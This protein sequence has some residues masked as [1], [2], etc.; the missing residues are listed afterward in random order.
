[1]FWAGIMYGRRA[2]LIAIEGTLTSVQYRDRILQPIVIPYRQE[3]GDNF[4]FQDDNARAHRSRLVNTFIHQAQIN[5]MKWPAVSPDMNPIEQV[6][7]Q[8]KRAVQQRRNPPQTL[9]DLR[10]AA[11]EEWDRLDQEC[12]NHLV[13]GV[14]RRVR[15]CCNARGGV[16]GY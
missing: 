12:L 5:R 15:A 3:F 11:I 4:V 7:D 1:M 2:P 9:D 14:P 8:L 10:R 13:D 6:W 16:T